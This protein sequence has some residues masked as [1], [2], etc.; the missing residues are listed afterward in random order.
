MASSVASDTA[1]AGS[2]A[3]I[4][5]SGVVVA[6][7][8]FPALAGVDLAV[9]SGELVALRGA[10]GTGKST[11]LRLCAGLT[12]LTRGSARVLG[13][14]VATQRDIVRSL[15][16]LLGHDNGLYSD[17]TARENVQFVAQLVGAGTS[18]VDAALDRLGV[19]AR[20]AATRAGALSAGQRRRTA[21]ASLVVRRAQL[22]LL[23]EPH[24]GLDSA[25]RSELDGI[26]REATRSGATVVYTTHESDALGAA[27]PR[28]ITLTSGVVAR[29]VMEHSR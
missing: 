20:V 7:G 27:V 22:W 24:A 5:L 9:R 6:L 11:L 18:D 19:D 17:L 8:G 23:D 1:K 13:V 16:G 26:L 3:A 15:V 10:N 29:D 21:L 14:D 12:P 25:A 28:T 4:L 2:G